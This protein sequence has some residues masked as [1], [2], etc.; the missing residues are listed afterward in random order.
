MRGFLIIKSHDDLRLEK[1]RVD[2]FYHYARGKVFRQGA[3]TKDAKNIKQGATGGLQAGKPQFLVNCTDMLYAKPKKEG[4][5]IMNQ[6]LIAKNLCFLR[7]QHNLTQEALANELCVSRQAVSK[8]ETGNT[9]PDLEALIGLSKLY[10]ATI[11]ELLEPV[12]RTPY[13]DSF[14]QIPM[15]DKERL[16]TVVFTLSKEEI[17]KACMGASPQVNAFL[18]ALLPE[19]DFQQER[20]RIGRIRME[21]VEDAQNCIVSLINLS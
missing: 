12:I 18:E 3:G 19:I 2:D 6:G 21:A 14:E 10:K 11:N 9:L 8:W 5:H 4:A 1:I 13:I 15:L 20:E 16:M 17:V 7:K